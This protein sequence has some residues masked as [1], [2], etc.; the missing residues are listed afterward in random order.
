MFHRTPYPEYFLVVVMLNE[1]PSV[2]AVIVPFS[3][4]RNRFSG[5]NVMLLF[6]IAGTVVCFMSSKALLRLIFRLFNAASRCV[7]GFSAVV[8]WAK[9]ESISPISFTS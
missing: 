4:Y 8:A 2:Y 6:V 5:V 7:M 9:I 3:L 1:L